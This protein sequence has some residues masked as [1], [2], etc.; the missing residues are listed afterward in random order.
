MT[1][2]WQPI[3]TAPMDGTVIL[4]RCPSG[5]K[6]V[7]YRVTVGRWYRYYLMDPLNMGYW[8]DE[9]GDD[10]REGGAS[11]TDWAPLPPV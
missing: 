1:P 10:V 3:D 2:F 4:L 5:Y 8:A 6:S 11:P 7:P 9:A